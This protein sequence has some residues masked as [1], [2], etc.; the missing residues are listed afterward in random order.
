MR[1]DGLQRKWVKDDRKREMTEN[2]V[3]GNGGK[4][5]KDD[6]GRELK[7]DRGKEIK[8]TEREREKVEEVMQKITWLSDVTERSVWHI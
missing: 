8:M 1:K 3:K 7:D 4:E 2:G 6:R 5:I